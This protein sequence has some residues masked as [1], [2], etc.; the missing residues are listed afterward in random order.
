M[1]IKNVM[2]TISHLL[3]LL[4]QAS[5]SVIMGFSSCSLGIP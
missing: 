5:R 2:G 1:D 4:L 3:G